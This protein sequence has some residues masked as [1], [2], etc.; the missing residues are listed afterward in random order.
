MYRRIDNLDEVLAASRGK[1]I[2]IFKHSNTCGTSRE[3]KG[4]VDSFVE[5]HPGV[6][7]YMV[8][9]QEQRSV[10]NQIAEKLGI[11]HESPQLLVVEDGKVAAHWSHWEIKKEEMEKVL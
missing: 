10:S 9:I 5:S 11:P 3:A 7:T 2:V 6:D 8:V 1:K 4:E